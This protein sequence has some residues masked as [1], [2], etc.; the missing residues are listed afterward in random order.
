M[1]TCMLFVFTAII[2]LATVNY[3][4]RRRRMIM[5][6]KRKIYE[7]QKI[8]M[9]SMSQF[10]RKI[11]NG[12]YVS[13]LPSRIHP[14]HPS[15]RTPQFLSSKGLYSTFN[16]NAMNEF[17][18]YSVIDRSLQVDKVFRIVYPLIFLAF[19]LVF[20]PLLMTRKLF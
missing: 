2:E 7:E 11:E 3:L 14:V 10:E 18:D 20:W 19:N 5:D 4:H 13:V 17:N 8:I 12:A 16:P 1:I 9:D 15:L 6:K